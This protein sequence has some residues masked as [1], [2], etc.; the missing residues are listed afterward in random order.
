MCYIEIFIILS[1]GAFYFTIMPWCKWSDFSMCYTKNLQALFK[2]CHL[3]GLTL[4]EAFFELK[5]VICLN[6]LYLK[7]KGVEH[8][9]KEKR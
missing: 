1:M 5:A 3:L 4:T 7:R 2:A 8:M 6:E 9:I